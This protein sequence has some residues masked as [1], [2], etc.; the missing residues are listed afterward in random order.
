MVKGCFK[1]HLEKGFMYIVSRQN[2]GMRLQV[3]FKTDYVPLGN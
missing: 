3:R 1:E 2:A